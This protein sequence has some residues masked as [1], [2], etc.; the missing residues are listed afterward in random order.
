[1][2]IHFQY[3]IFSNF[4][5]KD[6]YYQVNESD[7]LYTAFKAARKLNSKKDTFS[8]KKWGFLFSTKN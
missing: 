1:M 8:C 7:K 2:R 6:A 4:D 5:L 3:T